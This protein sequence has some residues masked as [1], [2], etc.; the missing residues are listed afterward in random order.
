MHE[1]KC[2]HCGKAFNMDEAGFTAVAAAMAMTIVATS[3]AVKIAHVLLTR[4]LDRT[5]Q[6]W[7]RRCR[8]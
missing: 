6:A 1:I 2:P 5:T 7:R 8:C 3:A 4:R